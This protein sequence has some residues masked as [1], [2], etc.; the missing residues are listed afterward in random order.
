MFA[1]KF[2]QC[3]ALFLG[4]DRLEQHTIILAQCVILVKQLGPHS[5]LYRGFHGCGRGNVAL[6]GLERLEQG[7]LALA[8]RAR[9]QE[10]DP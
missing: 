8:V 3:D 9:S 2:D 6:L 5:P 4:P 7:H 10:E 1:T